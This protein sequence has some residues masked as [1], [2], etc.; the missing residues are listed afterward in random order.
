MI[1][2]PTRAALEKTAADLAGKISLAEYRELV[3]PNLTEADLEADFRI[4]AKV[5]VKS[6]KEGDS[7]MMSGV[8]LATK[9][10]EAIEAD[11][12]PALLAKVEQ[13]AERALAAV[14][15]QER[16]GNPRSRR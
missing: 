15:A 8:H 1:R 11:A 4:A 7:L 2:T 12:S 6:F 10:L 14:I 9:L 5:L 13:V 16:A 3:K